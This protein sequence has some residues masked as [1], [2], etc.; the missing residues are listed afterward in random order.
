MLQDPGRHF[1]RHTLATL[2]YRV[3]KPLRDA[4]DGFAQVSVAGGGRSAGELLA[5]LSDLLEWAFH[6]ARGEHRWAP[7]PPTTWTSDVERFWAAV[8]ALD[9]FLAS[10]A[11]LGADAESL[12]QGPIADALTHT[13]QLIMLRRLADRPIRSENYAAA[14]IRAG[15]VGRDQSAQRQEFG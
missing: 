7:M 9:T 6:M 10:D 3:E 11:P 8:G 14:E 1:L 2:A 12:F 4:P 5:H 13:G 15:R